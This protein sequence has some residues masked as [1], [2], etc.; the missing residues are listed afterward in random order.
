M[1]TV[2]VVVVHLVVGPYAALM[3]VRVHPIVHVVNV[4]ILDVPVYVDG[5]EYFG[6]G[7][8]KRNVRV[9]HRHSWKN[10][11]GCQRWNLVPQPTQESIICGDWLRCDQGSVVTPYKGTRK[12]PTREGI[13]IA[14]V[15]TRTSSE[16]RY[17][18]KY[19]LFI[20]TISFTVRKGLIV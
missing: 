10:R 14:W 7:P 3:P 5:V 18:R 1:L 11:A 16:Q 20:T 15:M 8:S 4:G 12:Q 17:H 13:S 6:V 19:S 2:L 9:R